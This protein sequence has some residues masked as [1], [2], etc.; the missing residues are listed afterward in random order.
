MKK[1][2]LL[3][4]ATLMLAASGIM[5][6]QKN[7]KP[8]WTDYQYRNLQFPTSTYVL[9]FTSENQ[10]A[11]ET[12]NE[13]LERL[14]NYVRSQLV[15]SIYVTIKSMTTSD[16]K[17]LNTQTENFF[18]QSSV[19]FT[20]INLTGL[21]VE[22][23]FDKKDKVYYAIAYAKRS[24]ISDLY[25]KNIVNKKTEIENKL[26]E[27]K[28]NADKGDKQSA[29]REYNECNKFFREVEEAQ[30]LII[31]F[32]HRSISDP[33]L[34]VSDI[35][36]LKQQVKEGIKNLQKGNQLSLE[37]ICYFMAYN[38]KFQIDTLQGTIKLGGFTYQ[39]TK[40][41]SQFSRRFVSTFEQS[42][43]NNQIQFSNEY[44]SSLDNSN[45]NDKTYILAGTYWED[46]DYV[47]I[48]AILRHAKTGKAVASVEGLLPMS[49]F[50]SKNI[51][52]KPDNFESAYSTFVAFNKDQITGGGLNIQIATNK[53][54]ESLTFTEGD[55]LKLYIRA[56]KECY[57]RMIYYFADG[58]KVL[59]LDNYY[60]GNELANK[61]Y[62]FPTYFECSAPF[63]VENLQVIA[64][65]TQFKALKYREEGGYKIISD[66]FKTVL[67]NVRAFKQVENKDV[68][69]EKR[70]TITTLAK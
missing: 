56:N 6:A 40:M 11:N 5:F 20:N 3:L 47:K 49:W 37:D 7:E 21:T 55:T 60:I 39:D 36:N 48:T 62:E 51:P 18:R 41:S 8:R 23:Y 16:V 13:T 27:A 26:A 54:D 70:L 66:D 28:A 24:D 14:K 31:A 46:G 53:G 59:M 43:L 30:T 52:V 38:L 45:K 32:E 12:E 64:Q 67:Q 9:G 57:V 50:T 65:S 19:S 2:I 10:N 29:L 69:V 61:I 22:S 42:L 25:L 15:E 68:L 4:F 63:G 58:T 17:I 35:N 33:T 44:Y 1:F 34:Y